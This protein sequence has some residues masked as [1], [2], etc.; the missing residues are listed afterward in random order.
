LWVQALEIKITVAMHAS[1][2]SASNVS[3]YP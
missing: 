3:I 2:V 1:M